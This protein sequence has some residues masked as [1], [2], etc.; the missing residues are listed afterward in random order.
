MDKYQF[1]QSLTKEEQEYLTKNSQHISLKK[2]TIL[3]YQGDICKEILLLEEGSVKLTMYGNQNDELP[4]YEITQGEQCII[5]TSSTLSQTEAIATAETLTD[6]EGWLL[7]KATVQNLMVSS[8][9]YQSYMFSLFALKFATLTTLIED[10]KFKKLDKRILEY[11]YS[12]DT[13]SLDITHEE[14]ASKL[15]TSRVV[16]SRVLKE[17]EKKGKIKLSRKHI[18]IIQ[19]M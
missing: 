18:E 1:F 3:F 16:I 12:L 17:L 13:K 11:L 10:I 2:N 5:N 9:V 7:P 19:V 8:P 6:I 14:I 15:G 4:L